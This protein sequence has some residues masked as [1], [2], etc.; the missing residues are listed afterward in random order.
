M[1]CVQVIVTKGCLFYNKVFLSFM[2]MVIM[3]RTRTV[4][5]Y[6]VKCLMIV[7]RAS[8]GWMV[9][10][11][12]FHVLICFHSR[13]GLKMFG[14]WHCSVESETLYKHG[15]CPLLAGIQFRLPSSGSV[16][17]PCQQ[18]PGKTTPTL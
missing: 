1:S 5:G 9:T 8:I 16:D 14:C 4:Y 17:R 3:I 13:M 18:P 6:D 10:F 2:S 11:Q 7:I 12:Q 15:V